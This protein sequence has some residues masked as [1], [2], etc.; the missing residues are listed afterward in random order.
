MQHC[1]SMTLRYIIHSVMELSA[2]TQKLEKIRGGLLACVDRGFSCQALSF[3]GLVATSKKRTEMKRNSTVRMCNVVRKRI[4]LRCTCPIVSTSVR[5]FASH[6]I[7]RHRLLLLLG[8]LDSKLGLG[9]KRCRCGSGRT[10]TTNNAP[11]F[12]IYYMFKGSWRFFFQLT[13]LRLHWT[14]TL[15]STWCRF[16]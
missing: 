12:L 6:R 4:K 10:R 3:Q 7:V 8:A 15:V 11:S 1:N 13:S 9:E 5:A 2:H 16:T 14:T